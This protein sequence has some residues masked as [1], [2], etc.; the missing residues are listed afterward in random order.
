MTI[1][2]DDKEKNLVGFALACYIED[3]DRRIKKEQK[4][5]KDMSNA[6]SQRNEIE[7]ITYTKII[8]NS[9]CGPKPS[10]WK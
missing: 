8:P 2:L 3:M 10:H 7:Q 1:E 5:G 9:W 6:I 4:A